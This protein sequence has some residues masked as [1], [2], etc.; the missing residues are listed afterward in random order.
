MQGEER[1]SLL[2]TGNSLGELLLVCGLVG[3]MLTEALSGVQAAA[4]HITQVEVF[5]L[6]T[7]DKVHWVEAWANDGVR[8][9]ESTPVFES[10]AE[11]KYVSSFAADTGDGTASFLLTAETGL[12]GEMLTFRPAFPRDSQHS[13]IWVCGRAA[14][15]KGFVARGSNYTTLAPGDL[16][17]TCR[18]HIS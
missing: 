1:R 6:I 8:P 14:V 7:A 5:S 12:E 11:G 18:E 10:F 2:M 3:L 4:R 15:P 16:L 13:V 9:P 17:S